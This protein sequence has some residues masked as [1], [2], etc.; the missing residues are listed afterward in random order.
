MVIWPA[1]SATTVKGLYGNTIIGI[2]NLVSSASRKIANCNGA[3]R[4]ATGSRV[5]TDIQN[6]VLGLN[7]SY[8][9]I[10]NNSPIIK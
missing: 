4:T 6:R 10:V 5:L 1:P 8:S 3:L 7:M 2:G 9:K